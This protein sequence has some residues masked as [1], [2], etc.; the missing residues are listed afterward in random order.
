MDKT[1][2]FLDLYKLSHV[3]LSRPR[4]FGKT[5]LIS[6][7]EELFLGYSSRFKNLSIYDEWSW[8]QNKFPVIRLNFSNVDPKRFEE[9]L[10]EE[11]VSVGEQYGLDLSA[12]S[13]YTTNF[14]YLV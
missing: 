1:R 8:K 4:R 3:F 9:G 11:L 12:S 5:L 10:N 14:N 13:E 2:Y 6:A 7:L